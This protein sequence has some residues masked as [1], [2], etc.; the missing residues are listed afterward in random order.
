MPFLLLVLL[1]WKFDL[2]MKS[3]RFSDQRCYDDVKLVVD[4]GVVA[5]R[6]NCVVEPIEKG[7]NDSAGWDQPE[8]EV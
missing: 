6:M 1:L 8:S 2:W 4:A 3:Q 7:E 5:G